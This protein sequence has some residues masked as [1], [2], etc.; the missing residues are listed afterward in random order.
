MNYWKLVFVYKISFEIA[1]LEDP[2]K[3]IS[4][5]K[6]KT[7][8][9]SVSAR[10]SYPYSTAGYSTAYIGLVLKRVADD[11]KICNYMSVRIW[12]CFFSSL[13]YVENAALEGDDNAK[14]N[15]S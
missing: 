15:W 4:K 8:I 1:K 12:R 2:S 9:R 6:R 13:D 10:Y 5:Y 3:N 11:A 7:I 14:P